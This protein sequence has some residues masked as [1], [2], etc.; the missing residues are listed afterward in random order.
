MRV[1]NQ[2]IIDD[3]GIL[4]RKTTNRFQ[5]VLPSKFRLLVYKYLHDDMGHL[6]VDRVLTLAR[7]RYYWPGMQKDVERYV[8]SE[9]TCLKQ[10][11]PHRHLRAP[12]QPIIT[13]GST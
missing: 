9:C 7:D 1:W 12:L 4:H 10:K 11:R 2:L 3:R 6:G 8:T 13:S 5:L